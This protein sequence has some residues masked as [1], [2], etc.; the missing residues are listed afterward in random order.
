MGVTSDFLDVLRF[1][2]VD[3]WR[4]FTVWYIPGTT[5]TPAAFAVFS[6]VVVQS[7]RIVRT[8]FNISQGDDDH[9]G[10]SG[11]RK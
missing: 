7:I 2:F 11:R 9:S 5:V 6:L 3:L 10:R 4:L 8:L 1:L